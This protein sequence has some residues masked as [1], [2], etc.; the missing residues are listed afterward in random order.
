MPLHE[1]SLLDIVQPLGFKTKSTPSQK[2]ALYQKF[3]I[4]AHQLIVHFFLQAKT[5]PI[6]S[7]QWFD[8]EDRFFFRGMPYL[9]VYRI[10]SSS[11][12]WN[13]PGKYTGMGSH[14]LLQGIFP[15]QV[16]N[17][18]LLHCRQILYPLSQQ[19]RPLIGFGLAPKSWDRMSEI[20][21]RSCYSW[22][23]VTL[24]V[25]G[26]V[27]RLGGSGCCQSPSILFNDPTTSLRWRYVRLASSSLLPSTISAS[28]F[29]LKHI[30]TPLIRTIQYSSVD[31][32][33]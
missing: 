12:P 9:F 29:F 15:I 1:F 4:Q 28:N 32:D 17:L 19:G 18:P 14:S 10:W 25:G 22:R 30:H 11:Y 20:F 2:N 24:G 13:S 21:D 6:F 7:L 16:S 5:F 3:P 23:Y 8:R 31:R 33:V 27:R 26:G